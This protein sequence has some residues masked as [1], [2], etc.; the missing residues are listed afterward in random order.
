M[1]DKVR[2]RLPFQCSLLEVILFEVQR[3]FNALEQFYLEILY[4]ALFAI[5]Y[6]GL[7]RI[8]EV[9]QS[10]HVLK[11][12]DVHI[13]SNKDKMLILLFSSKTHDKLARPQKIKITSNRKEKSGRYLHRHFCPFNLL[14]KYMKL[15]GGYTDDKKQLF[16]FRDSSPV[17]PHHAR[18]VL[19]TIIGRLNLDASLY[20]MHSF[21]IGRTT[22]LIKYG[23]PIEEIKLMGRWRSN[24]VYKYVRH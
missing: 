19:R 4:K 6:Y 1:N 14:R 20:G 17:T 9:T 3:H 8:G 21:H 2:T 22:D 10:Q 11:A 15:R 18:S 24:V 16:V 7:M 13:A 12:R 5:C 23:Y